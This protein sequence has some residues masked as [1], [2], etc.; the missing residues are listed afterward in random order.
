MR[1]EIQ[2]WIRRS[3]QFRNPVD[4]NTTLGRKRIVGLL[5]F[6]AMFGIFFSL[7]RFPKLD[8]VRKDVDIAS[9]IMVHHEPPVGVDAYSTNS[10]CFQGFCF[11]EV[12][13]QSLLQRWWDF[14][15]TYLQLVAIGMAFAFLVAGLAATFLVP[16]N[17]V[18]GLRRRGL[19]GS[20]RGLTVGPALTLCSGCIVPVA[21]SFRERGA[22]I[23]ST[24]SI[25]QGSSTLNLPAVVMTMAVFTPMLAVSRISLS[26]AGALLIG[27]AVAYMVERNSGAPAKSF[28]DKVAP[29]VRE[30]KTLSWTSVVRTGIPAWLTSSFRV[31]YRLAPVMVLTGFASGLAIQW[32]TPDSV[33]L[34][35][36]NH[37]LAVVL[38]ATVGLL[39]NVPLM[40]E[41][42]LVAGLMLLGMGTAPA[43]TL[44][45]AAAAA[46]PVTF[47]GLAR[48]ITIR[49]VA[50]YAVTTWLLAVAG[51]FTV[52]ALSAAFWSDD[53]PAV[54]ADQLQ[55]A[56]FVDT[57][58]E[59]GLTYE[60]FGCIVFDDFNGDDLPDL[61]LGPIADPGTDPGINIH[62][63]NGDGTFTA[64]HFQPAT[65]FLAMSCTTGDIDSDGYTDIVI[66]HAP[67]AMT[68]LM[69]MGDLKFEELHDGIPSVQNELGQSF[70]IGAISLLDFDRDGD[71]DIIG[72]HTLLPEPDR[73][74]F[75][76]SDYGCSPKTVTDGALTF[77]FRNID[78]RSWEPIKPAP[79]SREAGAVH[80]FGLID[81]DRDGWLDIFMTQDFTTNAL[82]LN[83]G[84]TG[85]F[86]DVTAR[87]GLSVYNHGM[88]SAF[89]D[90][91]HNGTWD[92][93]VADL[94]PD[95]L[96]LGTDEGQMQE[97]AQS[98]G[99]W[100]P[101][102]YHSGWS[103]QVHDF[104]HDGYL[105]IFVTNS[106]LLSS[107]EDLIRVSMGETALDA[108]RQADFIFIADQHGGYTVDLVMHTDV[109]GSRPRTNG[110][111]TAVADYDG[112]GDLDIVQ[113]YQSPATFR[114]LENQI[115]NK[116]NWILVELESKSDYAYGAEVE[117]RIDGTLV[118][119]RVLH[120]ATGSPGKSW[121][122]LH[123]G[124]GTSG[125]VDEFSVWWPG[126]DKQVF[127]GPFQANQRHVLRQD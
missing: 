110:G 16:G 18:G 97:Q 60:N 49:G 79:G 77:L 42:P 22:S 34:Y 122:V 57:T 80:S 17:E 90:F 71:L 83:A 78:G 3:G 101:T 107:E 89:A 24:I 11:G 28:E 126:R 9:E 104:N 19:K 105:D 82:Y 48:H 84:G 31:F 120:G 15:L 108:P 1:N 98:L 69:G 37:I 74:E 33:S 102:L 62:L 58:L 96:W 73:C 116:G 41:I 111:G 39:I 93:Y 127:R 125:Q 75:T 55:T 45:F 7:N 114:L 65:T 47:W 29:I 10:G 40:F 76:E 52:L 124:L 59:A 67:P 100:E 32:L 109:P 118:G 117:A 85:V 119:R 123:F 99:I 5:L 64:H 70:G 53:T 56:D 25:T 61:L 20:L 91:D 8:T 35:L 115:R 95:Q 46:G 106:A 12:P 112:D 36:G 92:I 23:E 6:V 27:P 26:V 86:T 2:G 68:I 50:T 21:D 13:D 94:G 103:P 44:L 121:E 88:G 72:G 87:E 30:E 14:S 54:A 38:A 81:Y 4:P 66:A 63:N 113:F 51:G 43:A